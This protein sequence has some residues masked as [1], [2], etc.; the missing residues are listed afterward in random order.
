MNKFCENCATPLNGTEKFCPKCGYHF[1]TADY[2]TNHIFSKI[3][4][5][6]NYASVESKK[7]NEK[8][9]ILLKGIMIFQSICL[10][11][12]LI[13]MLLTVNNAVLFVKTFNSNSSDYGIA[14]IVGIII[15]V[16][17]EIAYCIFSLLLLRSG[18]KKRSNG[19][20]FAALFLGVL[21]SGSTGNLLFGTPFNFIFM[22]ISLIAYIITIILIHKD[23][24]KYILYS[25]SQHQALGKNN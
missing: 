4:Y 21:L 18:I 10:G 7:R 9:K 20:V 12:F 6:E 2:S 22:V 17:V 11:L 23:N 1:L 24:Q 25:N 13:N 15:P 8:L 16:I 14:V 19:C 3:E 5:L